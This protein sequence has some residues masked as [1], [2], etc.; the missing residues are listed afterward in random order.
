MTHEELI[1][2]R[3]DY[4]MK[5]NAHRFT[6]SPDSREGREYKIGKDKDNLSPEQRKKMD[7]VKWIQTYGKDE[8]DI[9]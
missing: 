8:C 6:I 2:I 3:N 1:K 5:H 7:E 9:W 4:A